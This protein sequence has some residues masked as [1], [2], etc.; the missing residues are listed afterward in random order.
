[1]ESRHRF[2]ITYLILALLVL[3]GVQTLIGAREVAELPY[4]Q[5]RQLAQKKKIKDL[6]VFSDEVR[7]TFID[8][9]KGK[10]HFVTRRVDE[11]LSQELDQ[12]GIAYTRGKESE[13]VPALLGWV[14]PMLLLLGVWMFVMRRMAQQ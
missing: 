2:T 7:G 11:D 4:S 1:M 13:V 12:T 8:P 6:V 10:S 14:L 5:F 9:Q 3:F